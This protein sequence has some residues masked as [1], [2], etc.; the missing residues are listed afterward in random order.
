VLA[1][2]ERGDSIADPIFRSEDHL[3]PGILVVRMP[4]YL[5][6]LLNGRFDRLLNG[7]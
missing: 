7:S 3:R 4:N 6:L 1:E 5:L 2:V